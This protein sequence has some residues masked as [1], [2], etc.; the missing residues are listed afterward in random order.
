MNKQLS[1]HNCSALNCEVLYSCYYLT[2]LQLK[3]RQLTPPYKP[4]ID[5]DRDPSNFDPQFVVEPTEFTPDD[6]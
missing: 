3:L 6:P 1:A 4:R 5:S 2:T